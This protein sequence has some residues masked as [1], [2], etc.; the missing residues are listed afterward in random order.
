[1]GS[2]GFEDD[3]GVSAAFARRKGAPA[4]IIE[5]AV[6]RKVLFRAA[7]KP[8]FRSARREEELLAH[9][10]FTDL[11]LFYAAPWFRGRVAGA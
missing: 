3:L 2:N 4:H 1:V 7:R 11:K 5:G 10:G 8:L 9:A 6:Q